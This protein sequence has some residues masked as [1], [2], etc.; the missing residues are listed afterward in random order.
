M[1]YWQDRNNYNPVLVRNERKLREKALPNEVVTIMASL[2]SQDKK[3]YAKRLYEAGWSFH[4][5]GLSCGVS[6]E[7]IRKWHTHIEPYNNSVDSLP[8]PVAYIEV[9]VY[10]HRPK[11]PSADVVARLITLH[12]NAKRVRSKSSNFRVEAEELGKLINELT[13]QGITKYQIAKAMGTSIGAINHRLV[14]YGYRTTTGSSK[15]LQPTIHR[16]IG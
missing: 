6:R 16:V 8:V 14:R 1:H 4:K 10:K 13:S 3:A 11:V 5:I 2:N 12:K 15:C 7:T 9:P